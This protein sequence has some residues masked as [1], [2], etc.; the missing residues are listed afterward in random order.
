MNFIIRILLIGLLSYYFGYLF[1]WWTVVI[2]TTIIGFIFIDNLISQFI[3][4]FLGVLLAWVSL[5]L[6][7]D[8]EGQSILSNKIANIFSLDTNIS[9]I[10]ISSIIGGLLGGIGCAFGQSIRKIFIEE[11]K[12]D[13]YLD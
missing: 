2:F 4:G 3:S 8:I 7:I 11:K 13:P 1:P 12:Q 10:I 5:L 9:L 6:Q